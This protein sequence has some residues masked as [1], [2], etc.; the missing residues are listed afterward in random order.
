MNHA[1]LGIGSNVDPERNVRYA[2]DALRTAFPVIEL[3][4]L[5]RSRAV[6][7]EGADF[8]NLVAG[9]QTA[10]TPL[11]LRTWLRNL[12]DNQGRDRGSPKFSNRVID[13]DILLY[14]DTIMNHPDLVLPRP[15]I[16]RFAHVLRPLADL[17][18]DLAYPGDG[19]TIAELREWIAL[20]ESGLRPIDPGFLA[21][22]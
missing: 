1:W 16:L 12:E 7:F 5:Y 20:D 18:P 10:M 17:S 15:E 13:V 6:G 19:R 3:S 2:I 4:P 9:V 11:E 8:I 22:D 21:W 14:D